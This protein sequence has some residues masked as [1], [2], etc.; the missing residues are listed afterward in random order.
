VGIPVYG[1]QKLNML[2]IVS[3]EMGVMLE[4][5]NVT[6]ESLTWAITEVIENPR[7]LNAN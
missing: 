4:F 3:T 5:K 7:Y 1:D 6:T 2:R